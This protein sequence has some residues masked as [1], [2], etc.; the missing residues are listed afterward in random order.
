M[1]VQF[2]FYNT[3][4]RIQWNGKKKKNE[5]SKYEKSSTFKLFVSWR[6][7][8][9]PSI[10]PHYLTTQIFHTFRSNHP[11][12]ERQTHEEERKGGDRRGS[13]DERR[14]KKEEEEEEERVGSSR[15]EKGVNEESIT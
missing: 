4:T 8:N 7:I 6:S 3:L 9:H 15:W 14:N 10:P 11:T 1:L 12:N 2:L 5:R 13:F